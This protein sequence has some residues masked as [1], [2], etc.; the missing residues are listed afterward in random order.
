[1]KSGSVRRRSRIQIAEEK[2][3]EALQKAET[4]AKLAQFE[5]MEAK[6]AD[7]EQFAQNR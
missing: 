1:M 2:K 6:I 3:Q 7:L 5:L 4:K